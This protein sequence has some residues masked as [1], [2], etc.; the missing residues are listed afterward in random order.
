MPAKRCREGSG[1]GA[2]GVTEAVWSGVW[3]W[4]GGVGKFLGCFQ[5]GNRFFIKIVYINRVL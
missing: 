1:T 3:R 5:M 4:R 2:K